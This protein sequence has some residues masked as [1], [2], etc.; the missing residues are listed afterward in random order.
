MNTSAL[1]MLVS[2]EL[3]IAAF[4]IY[5]FWRALTTPPRIDVHEDSYT[6]ND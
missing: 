6:D 1:I 5:F 2:S 4:T 3:I